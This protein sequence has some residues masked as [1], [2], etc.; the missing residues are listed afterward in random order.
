MEKL[1][2]SYKVIQALMEQA[3]QRGSFSLEESAMAVHCLRVVH[4]GLAELESRRKQEGQ[5]KDLDVDAEEVL[6][7]VEEAPKRKVGRPKKSN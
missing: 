3:N 7:T 5:A 4:G 6:P 1:I 2:E